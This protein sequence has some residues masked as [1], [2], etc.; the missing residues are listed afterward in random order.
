MLKRIAITAV[1]SVATADYTYTS[2][3]HAACGV[4][5]GPKDCVS[6]TELPDGNCSNLYKDE[7]GR[8]FFDASENVVN[9]SR[10]SLSEALDMVKAPQND[11]FGMCYEDEKCRRVGSFCTANGVCHKLYWN[12][13]GNREQSSYKF[14][15]ALESDIAN[16][17]APVLCDPLTADIHPEIEEHP[18]IVDPC[19]ALCR[20][21]ATELDCRFVRQFEGRCF[22]LYWATEDKSNAIFVHKKEPNGQIPIT[23]QD[24][25]TTLLATDNDCH[26]VCHS[27]PECAGRGSYCKENHTCMHLFYKPGSDPSSKTACA[28]E[29]CDKGTPVMCLRDGDTMAAAGSPNLLLAKPTPASPVSNKKDSGADEDEGVVVAPIDKSDDVSTVD[30]TATTT[31]TKDTS[32]ANVSGYLV[33]IATLVASNIF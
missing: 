9:S 20:L 1:V 23:I 32:A 19:T 11:C 14:F 15:S 25:F 13:L 21:S 4:L 33:I 16:E 17:E 22:R 30:I 31:T 2:I 12:T 8:V 3:C 10:L 26:A 27:V 24:A 7:T 28:G 18:G 5:D 6:A 29:T